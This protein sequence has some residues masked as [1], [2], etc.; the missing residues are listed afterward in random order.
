MVLWLIVVTTW[1]FVRMKE[2]KPRRQKEKR[3]A[4]PMLRLGREDRREWR[5]RAIV[6]PSSG[7]EC[8]GCPSWHFRVEKSTNL[9]TWSYSTV[10]SRKVGAAL[11]RKRQN[12]I[13]NVII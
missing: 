10:Q 5:T 2:E 3:A 6:L 4:C 13:E 9:A 1:D 11:A 7:S 12:G 8:S